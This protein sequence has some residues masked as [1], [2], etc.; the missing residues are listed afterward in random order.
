VTWDK[1]N[2]VAWVSSTVVKKKGR[3]LTLLVAG[4][5]FSAPAIT[6]VFAQ[7]GSRTE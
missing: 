7:S 3:R 5:L 6:T 2:S 4:A 1:Y